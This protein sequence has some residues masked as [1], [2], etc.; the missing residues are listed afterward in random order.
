MY[1]VYRY[2][3]INNIFDRVLNT[4]VYKI[5]YNRSTI[6]EEMLRKQY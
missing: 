1:I 3:C 5:D 2:I 6:I 4:S